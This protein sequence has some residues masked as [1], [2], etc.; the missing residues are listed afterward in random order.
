[1][2]T[3]F[4]ERERRILLGLL[5]VCAVMRLGLALRPVEQICTR[6]YI[7][8]SFY[9]FS[10]AK[11]LAMGNG[12][13]VDGIHPT[14]GVQPLIVMLYAPFFSITSDR[15]VALKLSF[16]LAAILDCLSALLLALL[17][18]KLESA[19]TLK[20]NAPLIAAG[21]WIFMAGVF[22]HTINGLETGLYS[23]LL[24]LSAYIYAKIK[25]SRSVLQWIGFGCILGFLVL[26]RIDA[27]FFVAA[28]CLYEVWKRKSFGIRN[29][30][31]IGLPAVLVSSPWWY[32]NYTTFGSLMPISGQAESLSHFLGV[33]LH[34]AGV[35]I[36][37]ILATVI[38]LPYYGF[39]ELPFRS[40]FFILWIIG[41]PLAFYLVFRNSRAF[42]YLKGMEL[43]AL[44]PI[45]L[46]ALALVIYYTF[47]FAAPHFI[48]RYFQPLRILWIILFALALPRII[49]SF[50][51][52]R[53][54]NKRK[55]LLFPSI[56][57]VLALL[58]NGGEYLY[59]YLTK[60]VSELY[61]AGVWAREH[62]PQLVGMNQSGTS[63][64]VADNVIN[65][66]GKVNADAL[67]ALKNNTMGAYLKNANIAYI[68]DW[69]E[70]SIRLA[71]EAQKEG[72][73]FVLSDSLKNGKILI[74]KREE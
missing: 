62:A 16:I 19:R 68:A 15:F 64:F 24:L 9:A 14:N 48:P 1:M 22:I 49:Q 8:D 55:I 7:E 54:N 5:I 57:V 65:L 29:A 45:T 3:L 42:S 4:T 34:R 35:T 23:F 46:G 52:K 21:L 60:D 70:F 53:Q 2:L 63:G 10:C 44:M 41:V 50:R 69:P 6:P 43:N 73:T 40:A 28:Y 31:L 72:V 30:L 67:H 12:F 13:T 74:Y 17:V 51:E 25:E 26:A 20:T 61:L 37:D 27:A 38:F 56:I 39:T 47:F 59:A 71:K 58:F 36:A 18:R 33:N 11:H 32:Y 66:D